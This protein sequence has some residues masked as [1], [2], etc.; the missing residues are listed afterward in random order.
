MAEYF[1]PIKKCNLWINKIIKKTKLNQAKK[2]IQ[3]MLKTVRKNE[4]AIEN[5]TCHIRWNAN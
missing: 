1:K 4:T 2:N 3:N 5:N